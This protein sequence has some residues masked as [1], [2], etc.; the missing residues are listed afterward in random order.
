MT[1]ACAAMRRETFVE[2]GGF[3]EALPANF[4]DVDL[5]YKMRQAGLAHRLGRHRRA[6]PL[7]VAQTRERA[8]HDWERNV[9]R[10]RWGI[11]LDDPYVPGLRRTRPT[12]KGAGARNGGN[13]GRTKGGA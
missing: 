13:R 6:L 8:V 9:V 1:A 10:G 4:N 7:R 2:I 3:S 5:C 12:G 11:P